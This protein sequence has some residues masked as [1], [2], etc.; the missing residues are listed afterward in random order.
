[1]SGYNIHVL[2]AHY[3]ICAQRKTGVHGKNSTSRYMYNPCGYQPA[4]YSTA[5]MLPYWTVP[6]LPIALHVYKPSFLVHQVTT[7]PDVNNKHILKGKDIFMSL[8]IGRSLSATVLLE[9]WHR[10]LT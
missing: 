5:L 2:I 8:Q 10:T 4:G 1:M 3:F 6:P 9:L 7:I